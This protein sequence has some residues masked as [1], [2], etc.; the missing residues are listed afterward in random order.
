[1]VALEP[2]EARYLYS[3]PGQAFCDECLKGLAAAS[4][5]DPEPRPEALAAEFRE[6]QGTCFVC[7]AYGRVL[8]FLPAKARQRPA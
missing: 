6:S 4:A 3:H 7:H 2:A 5:G 8:C 1:M